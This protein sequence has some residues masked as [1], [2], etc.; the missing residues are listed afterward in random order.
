MRSV[1]TALS[2]LFFGA[3]YLGPASA[4]GLY[5]QC[6][7]KSSDNASWAQCGAELIKRED[8]KLNAAWKKMF[9]GVSG[10]TKTDLL[11][12]QRLWIAYKDASCKFYAN[13]DWG[14]EGQVLNFADCRAEVIANRTKELENYGK[15]FA[16]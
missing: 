14:R 15:F 6:I 11:Q 13:G 7:S 8:E 3:L 10:Q 4:D 16:N 1:L 2:V 9:A 5:D 12:E